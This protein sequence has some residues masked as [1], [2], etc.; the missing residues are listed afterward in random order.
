MFVC[1]CVHSGD[2]HKHLQWDPPLMIM[3]LLC[4][5]FNFIK[6]L[7]ITNDGF[8]CVLFSILLKYNLLQMMASIVY[9]FLFYYNIIYYKLCYNLH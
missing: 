4:I 7:F 8:Y 5:I 1:L 3:L 2:I 9:S 6:I